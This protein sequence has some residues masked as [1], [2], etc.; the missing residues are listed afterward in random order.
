MP[1]PRRVVLPLLALIAASTGCSGEEKLSKADYAKKA[2]AICRTY[3]EKGRKLAQ[4]SSAAD[5]L[6]VAAAAKALTQGERN[7]FGALRAPD[8]VSGQAKQIQDLLK[9]QIDRVDELIDATKRKDNARI[10]QISRDA[11]ATDKQVDAVAASLGP[12]VCAK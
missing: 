5:V 12:G 11:A 9:K 6:R 4:R 7:D 3:A 8:G 1:S 10:A 2:D